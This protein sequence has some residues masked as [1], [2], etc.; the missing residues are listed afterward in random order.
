VTLWA[1]GIETTTSNEITALDF[2][3]QRKIN[4]IKAIE[5]SI[6]SF[7]T[8]I[9]DKSD[10]FIY[11]SLDETRKKVKRSYLSTVFIVFFCF[12]YYDC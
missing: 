10:V 6:Q 12:L 3:A 8:S 9:S 1:Y 5:T 11:Q 2:S 7:Q 4:I